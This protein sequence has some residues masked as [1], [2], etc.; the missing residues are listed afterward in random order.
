MLLITFSSVHFARGNLNSGMVL[1]ISKPFEF[2]AKLTAQL[3]LHNAITVAFGNDTI[4]NS[5]MAYLTISPN[6]MPFKRLYA[7]KYIP[8]ILTV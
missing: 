7:S 4:G 8:N 1:L 3:P 5:R 2:K 6:L